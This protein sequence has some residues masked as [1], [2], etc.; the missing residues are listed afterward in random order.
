MYST[1]PTTT[2]EASPLAPTEA[3]DLENLETVIHDGLGSF[4]AV[5]N[6]LKQI[7]ERRLYRDTH[8]TFDKYLSDRWQI[9]RAHG[10]RLIA[11]AETAAILSPRGDMPSWI[12]ETHLRPLLQ[13]PVDD[14]PKVWQD[15]VNSAPLNDDGTKTI[16]ARDIDRHVGFELAASKEEPYQSVR[17]AM[18]RERRERLQERRADREAVNARRG[19]D[20]DYGILPPTDPRDTGFSFG[21]SLARIRTSIEDV[22]KTWPKDQRLSLANILR[23]FADQIEKHGEVLQ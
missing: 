1:L 21:E 16:T 19:R 4:I 10:Y 13:F 22:Q 15:V 18:K 5:G 6:S 12:T 7:N 20:S 2:V 23:N 9:G 14:R 8:D 17:R 3:D 11:A